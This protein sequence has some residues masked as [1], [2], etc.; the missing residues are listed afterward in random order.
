MIAKEIVQGRKR[1]HFQRIR[2]EVNLWEGRKHGFRVGLMDFF[3]LPPPLR[4][5]GGK[6]KRERVGG[7]FRLVLQ[8]LV[9]WTVLLAFL[10]SLFKIR[11]SFFLFFFYRVVSLKSEMYK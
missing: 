11:F 7:I 4:F 9:S 6:G 10:S 3:F 8:L 2:A 1:V 5:P